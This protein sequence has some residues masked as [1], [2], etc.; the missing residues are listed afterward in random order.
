MRLMTQIGEY[1]MEQVVLNLGSY[2]N[3][4][5]KQTWELMGKHALG[6]SPIQLR[7]AN[8]QKIIPLGRMTGVPVDLDGV[9][10]TTDFEVIEIIDDNNPYPSLLGIEWAFD[11]NAIINLKKKKMIFEDG[12]TRVITP[13]DPSD[14]R[15][16]IEPVKEGIDLDSIYNL[17]S[18]EKDHVDPTTDG[19]L[20]WIS[21]SSYESDSDEGLENW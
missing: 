4:F 20:S 6:W 14:G 21:V 17:T 7:L 16:Y 13:I 1:D 8:Q 19:N 5:P 10:S 3:V 12:E 18:R 9:R 11:Y 2:V 15:R